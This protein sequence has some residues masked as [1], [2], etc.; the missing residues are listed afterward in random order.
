MENAIDEIVELYFKGYDLKEIL[1]CYKKGQRRY[2]RN[3][4]VK[5]MADKM[6]R[7]WQINE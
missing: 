2:N 5:E 6:F 1:N 7:R 3:N 4:Y